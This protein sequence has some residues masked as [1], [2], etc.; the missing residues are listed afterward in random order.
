MQL[1]GQR[2]FANGLSL[3]ATYVYFRARSQWFYDPQDEYDGKLTSYNFSVT[4]SGGSGT[5][6]VAADPSHRFVVGGTWD[7]PHFLWMPAAALY[8]IQRIEY[9]RACTRKAGPVRHGASVGP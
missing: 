2:A 4:Q 8:G 1:R 3:L 5:P 9:S 6:S 7:L